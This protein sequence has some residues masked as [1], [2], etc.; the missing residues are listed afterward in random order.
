V[1]T[2][3]ILSDS[4]SCYSQDRDGDQAEIQ[5]ELNMA[6]LRTSVK[7]LDRL[8]LRPVDVSNTG[9]DTVHVVSRLFNKYSGVLLQGLEACRID[10]VVGPNPFTRPFHLLFFRRLLTVFRRSV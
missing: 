10:N 6:C 3:V 5:T 2:L 1:P 9:D 7:L 4:R 8:Q